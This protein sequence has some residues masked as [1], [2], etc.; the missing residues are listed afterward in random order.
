MPDLQCPLLTRVY[1]ASGRW[2]EGG[3]ETHPSV[4]CAPTADADTMSLAHDLELAGSFYA[5]LGPSSDIARKS[6]SAGPLLPLDGKV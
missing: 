3:H 6:A 4:G 1:P 5:A 2:P